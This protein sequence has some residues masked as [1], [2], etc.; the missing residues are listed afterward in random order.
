M[1]KI[2]FLALAVLAVFAAASCQKP[3]V[4]DALTIVSSEIYVSNVG[5]TQA[6]SFTANVDWTASADADWIK[7]DKT[8]GAAGNASVAV[9]FD[10]NSGSSRSGKITI[11]AGD[12]TTVIK[13]NQAEKVDDVVFDLAMN[14]EVGPE[15]QEIVIDLNSNVEY[16]A[17][18]EGDAASW[19]SVKKATKSAP[20][21]GKLVIDIAAN[22]G[23][24]ARSGVIT[25]SNPDGDFSLTITQKA[26][27]TKM[28]LTA[29]RYLSNKQ[30]IYDEENWLITS[31][32]QYAID[33]ASDN[34]NIS[35][36]INV[37]KTTND[38]AVLP[39]GTFECDY[40]GEFAP[41]TFSLA[42]TDGSTKE[43]TS[44]EIAGTK[45]SAADGIIEITNEDGVYTIVAT[46][47]DEAGNERRYYFN[48]EIPEVFNEGKGLLVNQVAYKA[49][50]DTY[51]ANDNNEW[52]LWFYASEPSADDVPFLY[53]FEFEIFGPAGTVNPADLPVGTFTCNTEQNFA[54]LPYSAGKRIV[55]DFTF[56]PSQYCYADYNFEDFTYRNAPIKDGTVTISKNND[57]TYNFDFNFKVHSY[58]SSYDDDWNEVI[59]DELDFDYVCKY[60][61]V[62][63]NPDVVTDNQN[64]PQPD[65]DFEF[66]VGGAYTGAWGGNPYGIEGCNAFVI[67]PQMWPDI[68][69]F[70]FIV[71]A[72]CEY[73]NNLGY[74]NR[75]PT[76]PIPDGTYTFS[77][78]PAEGCIANVKSAT[79]KYLK[80]SYTGTQYTITGGSVTIAAPTITFD[81]EA[82][83]GD[84]EV[85][86]FTGTVNSQVVFLQDWS[87]NA[88]R[89]KYFLWAE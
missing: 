76:D 48:G 71:Y 89:Q 1:K 65:G 77:E 62:V 56:D 46:L 84:G 66:K 8:S 58:Y 81:L 87:T 45:T 86:K 22:D 41:G 85:A 50:Y 88:S 35:L 28:A 49:D 25:L 36:V 61:N 72:K 34:D 79:Y 39:T 51:F 33:L 21:A 47:F 12:K 80:N 63:I 70:Q 17:K 9:T 29:A 5:G 83:Y 26:E 16:N 68:Y 13:V 82:T 52:S 69:T 78:T 14:Y 40:A 67:G 42:A 19:L 53:S 27:F 3:E 75:Y 11:V 38:K 10:A 31:F 59:S 15:A 60:E 20:V 74:A 32:A 23:L 73:S 37:D 24:D 64:R 57:G 6:I 18:V 44:F 4:E 55:D 7:L 2:K 43:F 54:D 30:N